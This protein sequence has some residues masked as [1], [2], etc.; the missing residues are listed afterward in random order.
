MG[1]LDLMESVGLGARTYPAVH[2][3]LKDGLPDAPACLV[4]DVRLPGQSGWSCSSA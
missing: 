1:L 2:D 3:F 4:L